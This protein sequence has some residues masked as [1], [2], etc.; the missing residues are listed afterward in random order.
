M[1]LVN[2]H[3]DTDTVKWCWLTGTVT[4]TLSNGAG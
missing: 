1:V 3:S 2:W 4:L